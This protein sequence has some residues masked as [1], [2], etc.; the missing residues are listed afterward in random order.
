MA[1]I[2]YCNLSILNLGETLF[3]L[4]YWIIKT[5]NLGWVM[6]CT[7]YETSTY[8]VVWWEM[9][10]IGERQVDACLRVHFKPYSFSA[11]MTK[12]KCKRKERG[13]QVGEQEMCLKMSKYFKE[14]ILFSLCGHTGHVCYQGGQLLLLNPP[15]PSNMSHLTQQSPSAFSSR[16]IIL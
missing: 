6:S 8:R 11:S 12:N 7:K 4:M 3:P 13:S 10:E 5:S 15:T 16:G 2:C 9:G 14:N 1:V